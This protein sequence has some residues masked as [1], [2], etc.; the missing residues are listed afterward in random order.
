MAGH[1]SPVT[2]YLS[3]CADTGPFV[4]KNPPAQIGGC[5]RTGRGPVPVTERDPNLEARARRLGFEASTAAQIESARRAF[6]PTVSITQ[7]D[8]RC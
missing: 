3:I 5:L 1:G 4:R 8:T 7:R 6:S 2:P